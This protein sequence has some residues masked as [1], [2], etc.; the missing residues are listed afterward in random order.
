MKTSGSSGT[1]TGRVKP[2][3]PLMTKQ[4]GKKTHTYQGEGGT[5][6]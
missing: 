1:N 4:K 6:Q 3:K 5:G 2:S